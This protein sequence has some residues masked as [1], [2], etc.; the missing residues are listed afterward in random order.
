MIFEILLIK[1]TCVSKDCSRQEANI[2]VLQDIH[3]PHSSKITIKASKLIGNPISMPM[4]YFRSDVGHSNLQKS[5]PLAH[6]DKLGGSIY[7]IG[8]RGIDSNITFDNQLY[9]LLKLSDEKD[10]I[11]TTTDFNRKYK[12]DQFWLESRANDIKE[13]A[14][15]EGIPKFNILAIGK[16]ATLITQQ[17]MLQFPDIINRVALADTSV[18]SSYNTESTSDLIERYFSACSKDPKCKL[19]NYTWPPQNIPSR[20]LF[21]MSVDKTNF[22][23]QTE[24]N[25][26]KYSTAPNALIVMDSIARNSTSIYLAYNYI[27]G[28]DELKFSLAESILHFCMEDSDKSSFFFQKIRNAC[29]YMPKIQG[30]PQGNFT[31][32]ILL[33]SGEYDLPSFP[34]TLKYLQAKSE[35]PSK[36]AVTY[37][38]N[39]TSNEIIFNP[40]VFREV[41]SYLNFGSTNF[42]LSITSGPINWNPSWNPRFVIKGIF[43]IAFSITS[44]IVVMMILNLKS[45]NTMK[46][47]EEELERLLKKHDEV[48]SITTNNK[49]PKKLTTQIKKSKK[50]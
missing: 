22:I 19:T 29:K 30:L 25:L 43:T 35:N 24:T 37:Y 26:R 46:N 3:D 13:I 17:L 5:F 34:T 45:I 14:L 9:K 6:F 32:Q 27:P 12:I 7:Q 2:E 4:F 28:F 44:I 39:S 49:N 48:H 18:P 40:V 42:T 16:S 10:I 23:Y 47:N 31:S 38:R 1:W 36:V 15:Q 20:I 50:K 8:F 41:M 33:V 21:T 11:K